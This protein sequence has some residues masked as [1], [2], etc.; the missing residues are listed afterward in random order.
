[1]YEN[2]WLTQ[3]KKRIAEWVDENHLTPEAKSTLTQIVED[4]Y[5]GVNEDHQEELAGEDWWFLR[6]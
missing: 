1:M 6:S 3:A 4:L 5:R 2:Y